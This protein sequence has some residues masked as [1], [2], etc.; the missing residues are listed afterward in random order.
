MTTEG[1]G[2]SAGIEYLSRPVESAFPTTWYEE[3]SPQHFWFQWRLSAAL[4]QL[5]DLG[6]SMNDPLGALDVGCGTGILR[7]QI[8]SQTAWRVD[9]TDLNLQALQLARTGRG[10]T[11]YYDIRTRQAELKARYDTVIAYDIIEHLEE[12][13]EFLQA[14][15]W[16]LREGGCLLVNVPALTSLY[17]RY[18]EAAGHLRRYTKATLMRELGA[19]EHMHV[20]DIR[21]WGLQLV[22]LLILRKRLLAR[23]SNTADIIRS[24][25]RPPNRGFNS[26][27]KFMMR[28]EL[29]LLS[30]PPIGTSL[31]AVARRQGTGGLLV[32]A[33]S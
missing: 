18:D 33:C 6:V 27:L 9:I 32:A 13:R 26:L 10:R 7:D 22:P 25:L 14:A 30:R 4:R 5:R 11:L 19:L 21:F 1:A 2:S 3:S 12:P 20:E 23:R 29:A 8:E 28:F 16:H 31:L 17:S 15:T 24:G